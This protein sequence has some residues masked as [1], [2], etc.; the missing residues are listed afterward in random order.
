MRPLTVVLGVFHLFGGFGHCAPADHPAEIPRGGEPDWALRVL[1][2][3][4]PRAVHRQLGV[5][6]I[7]RG[8]LQAQLGGLCVRLC[9]DLSVRGLL[10]LLLPEVIAGALVLLSSYVSCSSFHLFLCS[11]YRGGKFSLPN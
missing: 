9:A 8:V 1:A 5:P 4:L 11:K 7:S 2:G 6:V 3:H 10:L